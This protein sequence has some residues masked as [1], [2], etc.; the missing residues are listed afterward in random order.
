M[1]GET[2][3][4]LGEFRCVLAILLTTIEWYKVLENLNLLIVIFKRITLVVSDGLTK[5]LCVRAYLVAKRVVELNR[6]SG[7]LFTAFYLNKLWFLSSASICR[8]HQR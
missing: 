3:C 6:K 2:P 4:H 1:V 7:L 8:N 5:Q